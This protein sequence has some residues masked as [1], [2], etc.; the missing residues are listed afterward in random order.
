M[1]SFSITYGLIRSLNLK[2]DTLEEVRVV[3]SSTLETLNICQPTEDITGIVNDDQLIA[4]N[5][6]SALKRLDVSNNQLTS[7][8]EF[9]LPLKELYLSGNRWACFRSNIQH[10][11]QRI[12]RQTFNTKEQ[13]DWLVS[14][15]AGWLAERYGQIVKD[16]SKTLCARPKQNI[17]YKS[18]NSSYVNVTLLHLLEFNRVSSLFDILR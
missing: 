10:N 12:K 17:F 8:S 4:C 9:Q 6:L 14:P 5:D 2:L 16:S 11:D 18:S 7:L 13:N 3:N 1:T 15:M